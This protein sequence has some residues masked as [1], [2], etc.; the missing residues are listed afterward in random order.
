MGGSSKTTNE[1]SSATTQPQTPSAIRNPVFNYYNGI[2]NYLGAD[3]QSFVTPVNAIQQAAFNNTGGLF[4][5]GDIYGQA[6]NIAGNVASN[7]LKAAAT[8]GATANFVDGGQASSAGSKGYT[9]SSMMDGFDRYMDPALGALVDTTLADFDVN[10]ERQKAAQRARYAGAGAFGGS[11]AAIGEGLLDAELAR[12]RATA[13]AQLR[14]N[15]FSQAGQFAQFDATGRNNA[16]QFG[17]NAYNA[18]AMNNAALASQAS[19]ARMNAA[20]QAAQFNASQ[21]QQQSQFEA[22]Q[23]NALALEQKRQ[24]LAAAQ[25]LAAIGGAGADTYRAD[26]ASQLAT[27]NNLYALDSAATMAPVTQLETVGGL[28]NPQLVATQTGGIV[29]SD[30]TGQQ[31]TSGGLLN[32]LLGIA[33]VA[34]PFI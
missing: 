18:A 32:G 13:D 33:S 27:G 16:S 24:E 7:P 28:L 29:N 22:A 3:P 6:A 8:Q 19:I 21:Q 2:E 12:A 31:K 23:A 14:S 17:A 20:N 26:L 15:A 4:G 34:A 25:A 1:K 5:A 10:A 30:T 11:R 9:S